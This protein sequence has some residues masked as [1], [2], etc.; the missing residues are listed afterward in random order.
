[1][2]LFFNKKIQSGYYQNTLVSIEGMLLEWVDVTGDTLTCYL[3]H[4]SYDSK[5]DATAM[6]RNMRCK[7][8]V[9]R[10]AT[11]L[12]K[13]LE[14]G[15]TINKGTDG[16]TTSYHCGKSIF[17][18]SKLSAE[19]HIRIEAQVKAPGHG[20]WW[21]DEGGGQQVLLP[22]VHVLHCHTQGSGQQQEHALCQVG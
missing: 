7:L 3:G 12:V 22:A 1:M 5:Q 11:Q 19:L 8:C 15:G 10:D 20:K 2:P 21:L 17:G 14:V 9:N 13:G 18:Q 4:W 6:M 16:A